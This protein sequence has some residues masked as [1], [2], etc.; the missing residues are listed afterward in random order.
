MTEDEILARLRR[1]DDILHAA[2]NEGVV[3]LEKLRDLRDTFA[4]L[5][6]ELR[7][8]RRAGDKEAS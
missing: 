8:A 7:A 4:A 3:L 2:I 6:S 5:A 1:C